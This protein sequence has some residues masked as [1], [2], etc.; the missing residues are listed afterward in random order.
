MKRKMIYWSITITLAVLVG[1]IISMFVDLTWAGGHGILIQD[2]NQGQIQ[3][4][5]Q[6]VENSG[7]TNQTAGN[8]T[9]EN[10]RE[11]LAIPGVGVYVPSMVPGQVL[12]VT[13]MLFLPVGL[14]PMAGHD[15]YVETITFNGWCLDRVRL[16]DLAQDLLKYYRELSGKWAEPSQIRVQ[17]WFK[18]QTKGI[19]GSGGGSSGLGAIQGAQAI[20]GGVAGLTGY[21][22]SYQDPQYVVVFYRLPYTK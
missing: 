2:I 8:I 21:S 14:K 20:S 3:G 17:V 11:Y 7:N 18:G 4:Q 10:P 6:Q 5:S 22:T 13:K 9:I 1:F 19:G 15:S 12:D 16:E